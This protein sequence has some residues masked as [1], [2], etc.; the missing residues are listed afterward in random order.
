MSEIIN[1]ICFSILF[2]IFGIFLIAGGSQSIINNPDAIGILI[3][4][5]LYSA[6]AILLN[7][8][9]EIWGT[10]SDTLNK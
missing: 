8:V 1:E 4:L 2:L 7:K 5:G 6:A 10:I 3:G 9:W